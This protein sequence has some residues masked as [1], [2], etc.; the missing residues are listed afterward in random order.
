M[1]DSNEPRW[2]EWG[3]A[4]MAIAQNGLEYSQNPYDRE[5]YE[6][7]REIAAEIVS[8]GAAEKVD[9]VRDLFSREEGHAT[10]KVDLRGVVFQDEAILLVKERSDGL[11]TLPGGWADVGESPGDGTA[12][13]VWEE[14]GYRVRPVKLLALYDRRKHAHT[15]HKYHIYKIFYLCEL[16]GGEAT[17]SIET[18]GVGFFKEDEIP[19]LS[20]GRVTAEQIARF[21]EHHRHPDWPTDFD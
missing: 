5:R 11:W 10:P 8:H 16:L 18:D 4:L 19:P 13:E 9:V 2:L 6:Q 12:R 7:V 14:S 15:P 21:F 20:T 17:H 3:K 1:E